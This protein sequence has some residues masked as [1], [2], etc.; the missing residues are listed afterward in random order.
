MA[1]PYADP[2]K[3]THMMQEAVDLKRVLI[4]TGLAVEGTRRTMC[5]FKVGYRVFPNVYSW[6]SRDPDAKMDK[7][8]LIMRNGMK[9]TPQLKNIRRKIR[10]A[11][12]T[13]IIQG[14]LSTISSEGLQ[15]VG[16]Y[17]SPSAPHSQVERCLSDQVIYA[18]AS[19]DTVVLKNIQ[20]LL[21]ISVLMLLVS[22]IVLLTELYCHRNLQVHN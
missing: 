2:I 9:Q 4:I 15:S 12:E 5:K 8:G 16:Q 14:A 20:F 21:N 11:F 13:G 7:K 6:V 22:I 10:R 17:A 3:M 18:H 1:H 19:V